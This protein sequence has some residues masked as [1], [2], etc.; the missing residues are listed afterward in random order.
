MRADVVGLTERLVAVDTAPGCPTRGLVEQLAAELRADGAEVRLQLGELDG[1]PQGN[2]VARFGGD[3]PAGLLLAG[4]LDTV[5]WQADQRATITPE[6]DARRLYGRGTCDMK[7]ALAAQWEAVVSRA[8]ALRR[9]ALLAWTW[10][11]EIGCHGA[12]ALTA[13]PALLGDVSE[14]V[15][16]V[17]EP[18]DLRPITAHKGYLIVRIVLHG[19]PA[20]S[21]DPWAGTDAS[22]GLAILLRDL[23]ELRE[24]LRREGREHGDARHH[25]P[26]T[27]LNTGLVS[28]GSARN[29]VP[30]RAELV[31]ELRP[32]AEQDGADLRRRLRACIDLACAAVPGLRA[33]V[34]EVE[35]NPAFDQPHA[36]RLVQWLE[37]RLGAAPGAVPFYTE[38]ELYRRGFGTPV[39]VCGPGSIANAHRVDEW[40]GFDELA[41]G[42]ALYADALD[43]FCG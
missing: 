13:E 39:V 17:G 28:A 37:E 23:H 36:T 33:E 42:Q 1:Q 27:T 21:S 2:L 3:G 29:V 5:P 35:D 40:V 34:E 10:G 43:A 32:V 41:A 22:V 38:A 15:A 16:L 18:T 14:A 30:D 31:V 26:G 9:P 12:K 19:E 11:E 6:R 20:H 8:D 4:H 24:S 7:G 25:P